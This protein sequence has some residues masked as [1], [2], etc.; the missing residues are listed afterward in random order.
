[1]LSAGLQ[2]F[3]FECDSIRG[4]QTFQAFYRLFEKYVEEEAVQEVIFE[5]RNA[6]DLS[7]IAIID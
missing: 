3:C 6:S 4:Q 7:T 1:M 5:V 2:T